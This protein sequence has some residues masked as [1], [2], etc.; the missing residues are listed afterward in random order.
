MTLSDS[1]KRQAPNDYRK[2]YKKES[3]K[4]LKTIAQ[5]DK[6]YDQ[7]K[8][9]RDAV[10]DTGI[11]NEALTE[12]L[13]LKDKEIEAMKD[14]LKAEKLRT[15]LVAEITFGLIILGILYFCVGGRV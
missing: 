4:H 1:K 3:E 7:V 6:L 2:L 9:Q 14:E 8:K 10:L 12:E 5:C 13:K 11:E 15:N